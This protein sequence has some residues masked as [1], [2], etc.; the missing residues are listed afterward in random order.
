[1]RARTVIFASLAFVVATT[2]PPAGQAQT[3][4]EDLRLGIQA[5]Q[6]HDFAAAE[7]AFSK[8]VRLDA[9]ARNYEYLAMAELGSGDVDRAIG[10][11]QKSIQLGEDS[12]DIH[13]NLGLAYVQDRQVASAIQEF[14]K[15]AS[16]DPRYIP[17]QYALGMT[18][19][20]QDAPGRPLA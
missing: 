4:D 5:F 13:Y 14:R 8:L 11:F 20:M 16:L 18:L 3:G 9:S 1:M 10:D 15:A 12:S 7:Q 6:R 19:L 2:P 17:A